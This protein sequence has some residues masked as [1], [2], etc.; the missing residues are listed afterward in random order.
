MAITYQPLTSDS[1]W[2]AI[3]A[4]ISTRSIPAVVGVINHL[5]S[6]GAVFAIIES[7]YLDRDYTAEFGAF[8]SKVFKRH[9]KVCQRLHF[10]KKPVASAS[11]SATANQVL[12][13]LEELS[14]GGDYLGFVVARP[15][16]HAPLG[17]V[18]VATPLSP[19]ASTCSDVLV[20]S[21]QRIHL[22]GAELSVVGVPFTQQ[23]A[24]LGACAQAAIWMC[25]RHFHEKHRGPWASIPDITEAASKPTDQILSQSL[26]A[27]SEG[28][29]LDNMVRALRWLGREPLLYSATHLHPTTSKPVWPQ[30]A[31]RAAIIERYI[32]SGIPVILIVAPWQPSQR[33]AHAIVVTG[34]TRK[35]F[36]TSPSLGARATRASF[37]DHFLVHD[38]QRGPYLRLPIVQGTPHYQTP[39]SLDDVF[40]IIVPLPGKVFAKAESTERIAR[41]HLQKYCTNWP[42]LKAAYSQYLAT[43]VG[44]GDTFVRLFSQNDIVARTYLTYGWKYKARL[45]KSYGAAELK[46]T[47]QNHD[48]PRFVWV[49]EFGSAASFNQVDESSVRIEA[50]CVQDA[51]SDATSSEFWDSKCIFHA[52]GLIWTWSH[53][54]TNQFG[55]YKEVIVPVRDELP[56]GMKIR[57]A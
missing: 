7:E 21:D 44:A 4:A 5:R 16:P 29:G 50:H 34:H 55:E 43:S 47:V 15:V 51:T 38:D 37:C 32:D 19:A 22:M 39:Y 25:A 45:L 46:E 10:F 14:K 30:Q 57:G 28:L 41:D 12:D 36:A 53:D 13:E 2:G 1:E 33:V 56:Y 17:R 3:R 24:R 52:P 6:A 23:D 48:F 11:S 35:T 42:S 26:P 18:N 49:T 20:R 40:S 31:N 54:P 9:T 8:Y 27:G